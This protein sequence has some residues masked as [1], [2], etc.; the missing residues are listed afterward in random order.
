[1]RKLLIL[2]CILVIIGTAGCGIIP[3]NSRFTIKVTG[4]EGLEFG[5]SYNADTAF[6]GSISKSEEGKIPAEYEVYGIT[7]SCVFQ[8]KG[9]DGFMHVEIQKEGELIKSGYTSAA[10]GIVSIAT[11]NQ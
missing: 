8:K 4:D 7:V 9:E 5:G 11:D 6:G 3:S 2:I 1:M 10:Y